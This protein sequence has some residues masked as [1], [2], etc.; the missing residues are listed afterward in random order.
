MAPAIKRHFIGWRSPV[1]DSV[2]EF[3]VPAAH[4]GPLDLANTLLLVPTRQAGRRLRE[5]LALKCADRKGAVLSPRTVMPSFLLQS[6]GENVATPSAIQAVWAEILLSQASGKCSALFPPGRAAHDFAWALASGRMIQSLRE[7]IADGGYAA[8]DI[9]GACEGEMEE[10]QRWEELAYLE[11]SY[12]DRINALG[13]ADPCSLKMARASRPHLPPGIERIVV[14][15]VP[16][17]PL[18]CL[19][20]LDEL[21]SSVRVD[22]L[23]AAPRSWADHFDRH[24][25]PLS[26]KWA[27]AEINVR[28][29]DDNILLAATPAGQARLALS[30]MAEESAACGPNDVAVGVCDRSVIPFLETSLGERGVACFDPADTPLRNHS[31]FLLIDVFCAFAAGGRYDALAAFLRHPDLLAHLGSSGDIRPAELLAELDEFQN[32]Y[33][34]QTFAELH[35]RLQGDSRYDRDRFANLA[36]AA[37]QVESLRASFASGDVAEAIRGFLVTVYGERDLH[38]D[39]P[40]E[41][42]MRH[43]AEA[44]DR[45]LHEVASVPAE[46]ALSREDIR[47]LLLRQLREERYRRE[48]LDAAIDLEGWLELPWNEAPLLIVTGMNEGYVPDSRLQDVFLP[49]S[50]LKRL[51]LR[52][53]AQRFGRDAYLMRLLVESRRGSGRTCFICGKNGPRGEPLTPSRLLFRCDDSLLARRAARLF[54]P[55]AGLKATPAPEPGFRLVPARAADAPQSLARHDTMSVTAFRD[56]LACPFRF[57]LKHILGMQHVDDSKR[58]MDAMD[59]GTMIHH[60][61][62]AMGTDEDMRSC[63]DAEALAAF[64]CDTAEAWIAA[65]YGDRPVLPVVMALDA[66]R[67]RLAETAVVQA[68]LVREGWEI[69]ET[70]QA[71]ETTLGGMTIKGRI[72]RIDRHRE[73]GCVRLVDYKTSD[74]ESAPVAAHLKACRTDTPDY[75]RVTVNGK[76][77]RWADLQLPLYVLLTAPRF[78]DAPAVEPAYF[79]LPKAVSHTGVSAWAG[80]APDILSSAEDCARAVA[81]R[82]RRGEF[83]PAAGRVDYDDFEDLFMA[84]PEDCFDFEGLAAGTIEE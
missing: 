53:D 67:Q 77:H 24:G 4:A 68:G 60:I 18:L 57:Y 72:D 12:L 46:V 63:E 58:V 50:L 45:V 33:I 8:A 17:P 42:E 21:A 7:R 65:R 48:P 34:P 35:G 84:A 22:I 82:V 40:H 5:A 29:P 69:V 25:R 2:C 79:N 47:D 83:L 31:L 26:G 15:C 23:V 43:A 54:A 41:D 76:Q 37:G 19:R 27:R 11:K 10:P 51:H 6:E 80:F 14:A 74:R 64:L 75:A 62:Q 81:E 59:F 70:E 36:A 66:A 20:A 3:L 44:V 56:Y 16:D 30:V 38:A 9:P 52:D 1:R 71:W 61:L 55:A 73:S 28:K 49:D 78:G 13:L 39:V 32:R